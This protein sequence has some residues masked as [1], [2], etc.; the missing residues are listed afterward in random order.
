MI[1]NALWRRAGSLLLLPAL[2]T[3]VHAQRTAVPAPPPA[4]SAAPGL[5]VTLLGTGRPDP[6]LD[7]FGPSTL[8]EA[9]DQTL[10][11]D[12]GRGAAQRLW[13]LGIPLSRVSDVFLTH[14]HSDHT[15]GLPDLWLT[16]WLPTPFGRRTVPLGVW[17]PAGTRA[18]TAGLRQAFAWDL[19]RR[20]RGEGLPAAGAAFDAHD[21]R[22][23]VVFERGG[24]RVTAFLVDHGG[25]L[26]PAYG[27]RVDYGG[28][29]VVISGDTRPSDN[30]VRAAA[31]TD[32]LVHEVIAVPAPLLARSATARRIVGFHTLPEDA[33]RVFARVRPRLAVYSHVVLLT[34][35]P[36]VPA[37]RAAELVPRTRTTY[38]GPLEVGEDL[39]TIEVGREIRV[40]RGAPPPP[41]RP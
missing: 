37:P 3:P 19:D 6:A 12:C 41:S 10:L 29:A 23:G 8:V 32:V 5:R 35:D 39:M 26:Q 11:F 33:G 9:G 14:L 1:P 13:Q 21:V 40:R 28:R 7:R 34:T 30:L 20:A 4:E 31:G 38:D 27:Y 18:M 2:A 16:G 36:A 25:I 17:G 24:V 22:P 15:V